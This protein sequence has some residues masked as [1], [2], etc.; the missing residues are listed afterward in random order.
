MA[1]MAR[2]ATLDVIQKDVIPLYLQ[3]T[4][5]KLTLKTWFKGL[6]KFKANPCAKRGGGTV[7]YSIAAVEKYLK[8]R[9]LG[10]AS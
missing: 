6:P 7:F 1:N 3:P 9:T 8:A 10:G 4:P 2:M 5:C